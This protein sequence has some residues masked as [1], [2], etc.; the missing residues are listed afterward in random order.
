M[1]HAEVGTTHPSK[2]RAISDWRNHAAWTE[3]RNRYDPLLRRCCACLGLNGEAADEV[4]QETWIEVAK[5]MRSFV[6]DPRGTFRGW[7]WKVCHHEAM[8]FLELR[9]SEQAFPLDERDEYVRLDRHSVGLDESMEEVAAGPL[10]SFEEATSTLAGLLR[11]AEEIQAAVRRRVEPHTWE[12]FWLVGIV[13]WTVD[14]TAQHLRM[15]N[16]AVYKAKARVTKMLQDEG[17]LRTLS[18]D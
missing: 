10:T 13:L 6:Y 8:D 12:A 7:L 15:K 14:E 11:E 4:C 2:L 1:L 17:R 18:A 5:R 16:A 3:F 9:R